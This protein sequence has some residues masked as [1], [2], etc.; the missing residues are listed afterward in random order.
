MINV[1]LSVMRVLY[2][3]PFGI[4][5]TRMHRVSL[6]VPK[7]MSRSF[8]YRQTPQIKTRNWFTREGAPEIERLIDGF[9]VMCSKREL[10]RRQALNRFTSSDWPS[11]PLYD[12][13]ALE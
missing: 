9:D 11:S 12:H 1:N 5:I 10:E 13:S 2:G 7:S 8:L 6:E 3:L 4:D